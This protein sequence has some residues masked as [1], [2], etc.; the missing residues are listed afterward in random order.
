MFV[1][2]PVDVAELLGQHFPSISSA[3]YYTSEF[4]Q[5]RES[6]TVVPSYS[7][8]S[9]SYNLPF[10]MEEMEVPSIA[11]LQHLQERMKYCTQ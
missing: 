5:I 9:E 11:L 8:N 6:T 4:L 3:D 2:K 1:S 10:S 7:T